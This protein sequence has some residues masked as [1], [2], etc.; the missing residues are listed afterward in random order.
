MR[1]KDYIIE[2]GPRMDRGKTTKDAGHDHD[3]AV[4]HVTGDGATGKDAGHSHKI[5]KFKVKPAGKDDHIH[6]LK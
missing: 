4:D 5:R 2:R 3:Y 6:K 1:F